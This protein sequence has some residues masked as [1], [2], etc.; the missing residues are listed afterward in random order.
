[1]LRYPMFSF[2]DGMGTLPLA[3]ADRL[4]DSLCLKQEVKALSFDEAGVRIEL[5]GAKDSRRI[6]SFQL[7]RPMP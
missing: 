3:L 6:M 5:A 4:H 1:M 7:C 2:Q